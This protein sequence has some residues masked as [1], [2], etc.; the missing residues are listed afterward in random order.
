M[1]GGKTDWHPAQKGSQVVGNTNGPRE[2]VYISY[3]MRFHHGLGLRSYHLRSPKIQVM[4]ALDNRKRDFG[5]TVSHTVATG[6]SK[7]FVSLTNHMAIQDPC[8]LHRATLGKTLY[9]V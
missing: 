5:P 4:L 1:K 8:S 2:T 9:M 6:V 7:Y 3:N